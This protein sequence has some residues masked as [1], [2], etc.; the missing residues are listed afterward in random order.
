M[1]LNHCQ[2][3]CMTYSLVSMS[4]LDNIL[5]WSHVLYRFYFVCFPLFFHAQN[6]SLIFSTLFHL[7]YYFFL[8]LFLFMYW[9]QRIVLAIEI[10]LFV[11]H[12]VFFLVLILVLSK[13]V[14]FHNSLHTFLSKRL[15]TNFL[16]LPIE[17]L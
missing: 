8:L 11:I 2:I 5:C 9:T 1:R 14:S 13:V 7:C 4:I 3:F 10:D 15:G 6:C 12:N 17:M 16:T